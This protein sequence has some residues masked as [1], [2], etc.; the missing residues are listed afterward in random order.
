MDGFPA[1]RES[2]QNAAAGRKNP[3]PQ[4]CRNPL[5]FRAARAHGKGPV[6]IENAT[7][8]CAKV[9]SHDENRPQKEA[10][11]LLLRPVFCPLF[12]G[13]IFAAIALLS[14]RRGAEKILT[15]ESA[16]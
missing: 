15:P 5:G 9:E 3:H 11:L 16:R 7:V 1:V 13:A 6:Q 10:E 2:V 8:P 12:R 4:L 14:T